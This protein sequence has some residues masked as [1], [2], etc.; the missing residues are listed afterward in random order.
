MGGGGGGGG[1]RTSLWIVMREY[2]YASVR[3]AVREG[4]LRVKV[5]WFYGVWWDKV[6][7]EWD[8]FEARRGEVR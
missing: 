5:S 2:P 4:C 8:G 7:L 3:N 6:A 1:K